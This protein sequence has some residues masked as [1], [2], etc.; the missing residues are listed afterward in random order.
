MTSSQ[1]RAPGALAA[2]S[3]SIRR[4]ECMGSNRGHH[5]LRGWRSHVTPGLHGYSTYLC[6]SCALA[7][8]HGASE[9]TRPRS[10]GWLP[11]SLRPREPSRTASGSR[12]R[13]VLRPASR[14]SGTRS[15]KDS[16]ISK[17]WRASKER[18][19]VD[20]WARCLSGTRQTPEPSGG[21]SGAE[22]AGGV[23]GAAAADRS[24]TRTVRKTVRGEH[25][26][27]RA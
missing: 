19:P 23:S 11:I 14:R 18:C 25:A 13:R 27:N 22:W 20:D 6:V 3:V 8:R 10:M 15:P 1:R 9:S 21:L 2:S 26:A 5:R 17:S 7:P 24:D 4:C 12:D 16:L